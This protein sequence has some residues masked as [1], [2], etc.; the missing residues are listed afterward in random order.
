MKRF[1]REMVEE[2][3]SGFAIQVFIALELVVVDE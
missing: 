3:E 2:G 1:E